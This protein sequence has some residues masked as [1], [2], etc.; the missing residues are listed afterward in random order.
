MNPVDALWDVVAAVGRAV[1]DGMTLAAEILCP[2]DHTAEDR[3][4]AWESAA[5]AVEDEICDEADACESEVRQ[6]ACGAGYATAAECPWC[7]EVGECICWVGH[8]DC[9]GC[10]GVPGISHEPACGWDW[11]PEC[12]QHGEG[13]KASAA[14]SA[15]ADP[16]PARPSPS[17]ASAG[18]EG[19][20]GDSD[21]LPSPP[22]ERPQCGAQYWCRDL[23]TCSRPLGH[24]GDH[25]YAGSW[26]KGVGP[27]RGTCVRCGRPLGESALAAD[28]GG[29]WCSVACQQ[30][31]Q[32]SCPVPLVVAG[33]SP[34]GVSTDQPS[35]G[36]P[37]CDNLADLLHRAADVLF[38][39][40][41][42][43]PALIAE[44]R[45][46]ADRFAAVESVIGYGRGTAGE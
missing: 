29:Y 5:V 39:S 18:G 26:A 16:S 15:A 1:A 20:G 36:E 11:N 23:Y 28:Q 25:G 21:I 45:T 24:D 35:L 7:R 14:V 22:P 33:E 31:D 3:L 10:S 37:I 17:P 41:A 9:G 44:L 13:L 6:C 2:R 42:H 34:R 40:D 27:D 32:D 12:P 4:Q 38:A 8:G 19:S 46:R 30:L 43:C